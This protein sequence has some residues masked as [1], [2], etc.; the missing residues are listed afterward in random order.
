MVK[1]ASGASAPRRCRRLK[2]RY[3]CCFIVCLK[4]KLL[5]QHEFLYSCRNVWRAKETNAMAQRKV[6][7][8]NIHIRIMLSMTML[9]SYTLL[10]S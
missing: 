10:H 5:W 7:A 3:V 1:T 9:I 4:R 8:Y 2:F 6:Y